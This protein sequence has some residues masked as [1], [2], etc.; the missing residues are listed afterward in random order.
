MRDAGFDPLGMPRFLRL[1]LKTQQLNPTQ[2][3]P[4]FLSHPLTEDRITELEQLARAMPRARPRPGGDADLAAAQATV[5]AL[6]GSREKVVPAYE[7]RLARD[8][9]NALAECRGK[10]GDER[11]QWWHLA[12]AYELRGEYDRARNAYEK[13]RD[14]APNDTPERKDAEEAL[15][16]LRAVL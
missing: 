12:R 3:P 10:S 15:K 6:V 5:R 1:V 4:Y 8:P 13:A 7:E 16:A 2:V 14:L 11:Q 9:K